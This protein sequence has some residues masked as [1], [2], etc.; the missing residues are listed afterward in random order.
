MI[1]AVKFVNGALKTV[2][3]EDDFRAASGVGV[4]VSA[5]SVREAVEAAVAASEEELSKDGW[6]FFVKLMERTK[7]GLP[8]ASGK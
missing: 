6:F 8:F 4:E 3:L 2:V 5:A 7:Q 1:A